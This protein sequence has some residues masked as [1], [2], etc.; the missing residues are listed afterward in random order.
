MKLSLALILSIASQ[1][2]VETSLGG[3]NVETPRMAPQ[4]KTMDPDGQCVAEQDE[5]AKQGSSSEEEE[6]IQSL[7]PPKCGMY[8]AESSIPNS[9]WGMYSNRDIEQGSE[10]LPLDAVVQ[11]L[12]APLAVR[13]G[14]SSWLLSEYV[15]NP[16]ELLHVRVDHDASCLQ[17]GWS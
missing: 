5:E 1:W 6:D 2:L 4:C 7:Y 3:T 10:I 16:G 11:V 17:Q 15:W 13:E 14:S 12:D 9:G 8:L